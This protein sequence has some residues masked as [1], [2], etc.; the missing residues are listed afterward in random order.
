M[1]KWR[2]NVGTILPG[3]FRP[4]IDV[5]RSRARRGRHTGTASSR[6][7]CLPAPYLPADT[8]AGL[9]EK[10]HPPERQR[11]INP[12]GNR[13]LPQRNQ[14]HRAPPTRALNSRE[15]IFRRGSLPTC[16][17][18][19]FNFHAV[20]GRP[21]TKENICRKPIQRAANNMRPAVSNKSGNK[22]ARYRKTRTRCKFNECS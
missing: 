15:N 6:E 18:L 5:H 8:M 17:R 22:A 1:T 12:H 20:R 16:L 13:S 19:P 3:Y 14:P 7:W 2:T 11:A 9:A 10:S 21:Y 4:S